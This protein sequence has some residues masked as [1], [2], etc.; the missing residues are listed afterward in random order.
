MN[1]KTKN[2]YKSQQFIC[3]KFKLNQLLLIS[4]SVALAYAN[5]AVSLNFLVLLVVQQ[6]PVITTRIILRK[7]NEQIKCRKNPSRVSG[8]IKMDSDSTNELRYNS[9]LLFQRMK[10]FAYLFS[11]T[12]FQIVPLLQAVIYIT[13]C[14]TAN[15]LP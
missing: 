6:W 8:T 13:T 15:G 12:G 10:Q 11:A 9:F 7:G 4:K 5:K 14:H 3:T 1:S 2:T